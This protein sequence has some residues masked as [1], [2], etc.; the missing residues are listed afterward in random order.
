MGASRAV[1]QMLLTGATERLKASM[2]AGGEGENWQG[3]WNAREDAL[4]YP[5]AKKIQDFYRLHRKEKNNNTLEG[6]LGCLEPN[7]QVVMRTILDRMQTLERRQQQMT[8]RI[9]AEE[10]HRHPSSS[11]GGEKKYWDVKN[12]WR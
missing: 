11:G 2:E 12:E 8:R 10:D 4:H 5:Y 6:A 3:H 7:M 1:L 9:E